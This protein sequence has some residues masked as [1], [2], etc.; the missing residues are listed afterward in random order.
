MLFGEAVTQLAICVAAIDHLGKH[1]GLGLNKGHFTITAINAI[2]PT[3][4]CVP[5]LNEQGRIACIP[6]SD[7]NEFLQNL[8]SA[9]GI[10]INLNTRLRLTHN[11]QR[12][13]HAPSF[14]M[15][16]TR[17]IG[18]IKNLSD[19]YGESNLISSAEK[20]ELIEAAKTIVLHSQNVEWSEWSRYSGRQKEWMKF[21]GLLGAITCQGK[22]EP[23]LPWLALGEWTHVGGKTSFGLGKYS[24]EM[25]NI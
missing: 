20:H 5:V 10:R 13:T 17:L 21:G 24:L 7:S 2:K 23:F 11:N 18:R 3:G 1:L 14:E 9:S 6:E 25:E 4:E 12:I 19:L 8:Q 22:L 15:L 16:I